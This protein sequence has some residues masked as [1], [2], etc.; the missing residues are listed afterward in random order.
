MRV[1]ENMLVWSWYSFFFKI[2]LFILERVWAC[3]HASSG[4]GRTEGE[5]RISNRLPI[6][7]GAPSQDSEIMTW[8]KTKSQLIYRLSHP[9]TPGHGILTKVV[10]HGLTRGWH[11]CR[12]SMKWQTALWSHQSLCD[13]MLKDSMCVTC[14]GS[15]SH[16]LRKKPICNF[17]SSVKS[18]TF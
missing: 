3:V 6:E 10:R 14:T 9:G 11:L 4:G 12:D 8:A 17:S 15:P 5:E 1:I 7:H 16:V 18:W 2:Y 13:S